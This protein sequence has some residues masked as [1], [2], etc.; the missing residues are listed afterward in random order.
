VRRLG[1]TTPEPVDAWIISATNADL[2]G[3][4]RQH[5]FREDL[6]HRLAVLTLRLPP[7][8]ERGRDILILA[9]RFLGRVCADYALPAKR[10]ARE[11][12]ARLLAYPWPGNIRELGNVIERVALLAE[13]E[14]VTADMLELQPM[15]ES[16]RLPAP[17]AAISSGSL[18]DVMRD[19]VLTALTQNGWNISRTAALLSISRNTLRSRIDKLGLRPGSRPS[20][21]SIRGKR[22]E[23]GTP[24]AP[25]GSV[26][27]VPAPVGPLPIRWEQRRVTFM[28][29][30]VISREDDAM[31][32]DRWR[33]R[34]CSADRG[35]SEP[36]LVGALRR[37]H[38]GIARS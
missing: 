31:V 14:I 17:S 9:E 3:A 7:L 25:V 1:A 23:R 19:H 35:D 18:D 22:G 20:A 33:R 5:N 26:A 29:V 34:S 13:S 10:L 38:S 32:S 6:Y 15:G 8:R 21:P 24:A 16:Q 37:S 27:H 11:A 4:V 2:Q 36:P 28:R 30:R 12:E